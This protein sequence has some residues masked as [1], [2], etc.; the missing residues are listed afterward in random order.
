MVA[1]TSG[2]RSNTK[3]KIVDQ[4]TSRDTGLLMELPVLVQNQLL[5]LSQL[6]LKVMLLPRATRNL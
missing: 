3:E 2:S 1:L 4:S 6:N 5:S